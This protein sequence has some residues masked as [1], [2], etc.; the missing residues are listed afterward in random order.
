MS[1]ENN[2]EGTTQQEHENEDHSKCID[3]SYLEKNL[4]KFYNMLKEKLKAISDH[5]SFN[6][7]LEV[8]DAAYPVGTYYFTE[9]NLNPN[10]NFVGSWTLVHESNKNQNPDWTADPE[11]V[12][13][14]LEGLNI[15]KRNS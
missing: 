9:T 5:L 10:E 14:L 13:S 6:Q 7:K 11:R 15:W 2:V 8:M 1:D 3:K 4:K 12:S